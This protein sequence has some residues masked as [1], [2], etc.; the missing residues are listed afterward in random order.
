MVQHDLPVLHAAVQIDLIW[1]ADLLQNL[2][3]LVPFIARENRVG[4]GGT[5]GQWALDL[6]ELLTV[7]ETRVRCVPGIDLAGVGAQMA[8]D[9]LAAE[10]IAYSPDFLCRSSQSQWHG[11]G[12]WVLIPWPYTLS[13]ARSE[14]HR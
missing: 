2:L 7:H 12:D 6:L 11:R 14:R 10:A 9:V 4:L 8:Y 5:D 3:R 13:A 1:H